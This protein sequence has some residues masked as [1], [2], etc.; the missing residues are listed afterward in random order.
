MYTFDRLL[1]I[2]G[3]KKLST[4]GGSAHLLTTVMP[5]WSCSGML[6]PM[7]SWKM[8]NEITLSSNMCM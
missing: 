3:K 6:A 8:P 1:D 5:G 7:G 4:A 2:L